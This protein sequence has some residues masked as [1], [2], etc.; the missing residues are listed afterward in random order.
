MSG[1]GFQKTSRSARSRGRSIR[2][3]SL[4]LPTRPAQ[5]TLDQQLRLNNRSNPDNAHKAS[6][7]GNH[8]TIL[9]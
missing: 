6:Y 2:K 5:E 4:F 8:I 1:L 9:C 7:N 3:P